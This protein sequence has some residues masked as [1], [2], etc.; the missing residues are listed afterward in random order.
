MR[1]PCWILAPALIVTLASAECIPFDKAP[2]HIGQR[3]CVTGRVVRVGAGNRGVRYLDFCEDYRLCSFTVVVFPHDLKNVGDVRQLA[4]RLIEIRGEV[5]EYEGRAEIILES[6]KQLGG[7]AGVIPP[8]PKSFDAEQ[9]GH[10]SAG[11]FRTS[12]KRGRTKRPRP[13]LPA[14]IPED[15]E[16]E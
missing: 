15:V 4:G 13:T 3:Q 12:Q 6:R 9:R 1:I 7:E 14:Q 11:K 10:F 8:L 5:K 16:S 2:E